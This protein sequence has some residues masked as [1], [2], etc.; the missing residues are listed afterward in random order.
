[1][2]RSR[3]G[4]P[5]SRPLRP[6][7]KPRQS[8]TPGN[9]LCRQLPP[10]QDCGVLTHLNQGHV[11]TAS[12]DHG[13]TARPQLQGTGRR[14]SR[15]GLPA[16]A[17]TDNT[18]VLNLL[19]HARSTPCCYSSGSTTA[20]YPRGLFAILGIT[21]NPKMIGRTRRN[22]GNMQ[23]LH[24]VHRSVWDSWHPGLGRPGEGCPGPN[25]LPHAKGCTHSHSHIPHKPERQ[26]GKEAATGKADVSSGKG[27]F[28]L[29]KAIWT[30]ITS[31]AG[32]T[33]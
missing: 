31:F 10:T 21:H 28:F 8:W 17:A 3:Q 26:T 5:R 14:P 7:A 25:P 24:S 2:G 9:E 1:M 27:S 6:R 4:H 29:P 19:A 11:F 30:F 33:Q 32:L 18:L 23:L 22:V 20:P 13:A 16:S 15:C 12:S